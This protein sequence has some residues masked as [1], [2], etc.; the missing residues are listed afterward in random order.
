MKV[1]NKNQIKN[2]KKEQNNTN[3]FM[4]EKSKKQKN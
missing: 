3:N 4:K 2:I 1:R